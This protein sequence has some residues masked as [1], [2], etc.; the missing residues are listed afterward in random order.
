MKR[1]LA[2]KERSR[3]SF[4]ESIYIPGLSVCYTDYEDAVGSLISEFKDINCPRIVFQIRNSAEKLL[5]VDKITQNEDDSGMCLKARVKLKI[6]SVDQHE[7]DL[8]LVYAQFE[9]EQ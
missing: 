4:Y 2:Q 7:E 3:N 5:E 1:L 9:Q 8:I 6:E